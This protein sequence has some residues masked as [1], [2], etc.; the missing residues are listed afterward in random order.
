MLLLLLW[1]DAKKGGNLLVVKEEECLYGDV[2]NMVLLFVENSCDADDN[3]CNCKDSSRMI[4]DAIT[5]NDLNNPIIQ[6]LQ[7]L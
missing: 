1:Y 5:S 2:N 3:G 7:G 4:E 6:V